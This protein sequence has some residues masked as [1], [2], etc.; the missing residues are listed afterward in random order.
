MAADDETLTA[1]YLLTYD[2]RRSCGPVIGRF[3]AG[4]RAGRIEGVRTA[5]GRVIVPPVE[6]DPDNGEPT[7]DFVAVSSTGTVVSWAWVVEPRPNHPLARPFA[8]ALIKLDGADTAM[9]H[10]VD[11]GRPSRIKTGARVKA[12]FAA[13]RSGHI[14]DL[15]C[16]EL[17]DA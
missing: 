5:G 10:A 6:Y 4:L 16:F 14:R 15:A 17:E 1:P 8:W 3:L 2:Y 7:G 9:L 13:E 11:A 12:R